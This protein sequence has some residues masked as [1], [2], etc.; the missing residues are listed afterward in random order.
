MSGQYA[1]YPVRGSGGGGGGG[2]DI[3]EA[4]SGSINNSNTAFTLSQTPTANAAVKLYQDGLILIQGTDYTIAS[5]TITMTTA[6]DFGQFLYAVYT[7]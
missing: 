4:P 2:T 5:T 3:Q 7:Y 1:R 6:P